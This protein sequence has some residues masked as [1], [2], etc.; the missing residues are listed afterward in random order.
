MSKKTF[1]FVA[2]GGPVANEEKASAAEIR[3]RPVNFSRAN[4]RAIRQAAQLAEELNMHSFRLHGDGVPSPLYAG[5]TT[6]QRRP[7]R[8]K[9]ARARRT[10][11]RASP[12]SALRKQSSAHAHT[13][14]CTRRQRASAVRQLY[15]TG[16][17][18][19]AVL[20]VRA[21]RLRRPLMS[22][23]MGSRGRQMCPSWTPTT[24]APR[25]RHVR[26]V[27]RCSLHSL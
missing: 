20:R 9:I 24:P 1:T 21:Q 19:G 16:T 25:G 7:Q 18:H 11:R 4:R 8:K 3:G 14:S 2:M 23:E 22:R 15:G 6:L 12:L 26:W 5:E 27:S 17:S 13:T 10:P